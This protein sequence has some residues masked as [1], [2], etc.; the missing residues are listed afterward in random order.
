MIPTRLQSD[1]AMADDCPCTITLCGYQAYLKRLFGIGLKRVFYYSNIRI[2][3]LVFE[4]LFQRKYI[5]SVV[6]YVEILYST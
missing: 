5:I 3:F 6:E 4:Y 2:P 1:H